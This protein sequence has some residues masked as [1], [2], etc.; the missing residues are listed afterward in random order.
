[1][2]AR[3]FLT[4]AALCLAP[5]AGLLSSQ[6]APVFRSGVDLVTVDVSV[7]DRNG[8][9]VKGL[10]PE[11]FE[12]SVDGT[13]RR[14]AWV[15]YVGYRESALEPADRAPYFSSN[16]DVKPGRVL[17]IAVDQMHI[18]RV[19]GLAALR[20]AANLVESLEPTDLAAAVPLDHVG[21]LEFTSDHTRVK[22]QLSTLTGQSVAMPVHF[23]IG[24][25]EALAISDGNRTRLDLVVRR[26]CG[27]PLSRLESMARMAEN[28]FVRDPCPVQIEQ[29]GRALAQQARTEARMSID[30][31]GR[32]LV[33]LADIEGPKTLVLISEGLIAEPQLF[34]LTSLGAAAQAA[35]VTIYVLQLETPI[36]EASTDAVSPSLFADI[37]LRTDGLARLTGT[38][39]GAF[40]RLVGSDPHP[41]QRILREISGHY[42]VAFEAAEPDRDGRT[43]RIA[44]KVRADD[45]IVRARPA[46]RISP[47]PPPAATGTALERLL[48]SPR[49]STGLPL[50]L[51]AY[52]F[53]QQ[54]TDQLKV[55]VSAETD[56]AGAGREVTIGFVVIDDAGV[57]AASGATTT[58][59]GRF[60][61]PATL[62][63]GRYLIRAAAIDSVGDRQGS[64]ERRFDARLTPAGAVQLS[65][66]MIAEPTQDARAPL[67]PT[68][69][70]ASSD[71][72][73]L[74]LE[75]YAPTTTLP[76][77]SSVRIDVTAAGE[78]SPALSAPA[79][80][81]GA[82]AQ[83]WTATAEL[84]LGSLAPGPYL[85]AAVVTIPG[86]PPQRLTRSFVVTRGASLIPDR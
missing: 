18:K 36:V 70:R 52:A 61:L 6:Q 22:R 15:E 14:V 55:I 57:I 37:Q 74:Y 4:L 77:G 51:A 32:M 1:M 8:T 33:R 58:G 65:D 34:D 19:E 81:R 48:R 82:G 85:A 10:G 9:P 68:V 28:N 5:G 13:P 67:R 80:L 24:I 78:S 16:E 20:A 66:L 7:L 12:V 72:M 31:V 27:E 3:R 64:V 69:A 25:S 30:A 44:V 79:A 26:E 59:T 54:G 40:F 47:T 83:R 11:R 23:N 42:L 56:H 43:H 2:I 63:S 50:R 62:P 84:A 75:A 53:P 46:F 41:F 60:S 21:A 35:R 73:I 17:L 39:R 49:L 29:E 86:A 38:A 71:R 76:A 45:T